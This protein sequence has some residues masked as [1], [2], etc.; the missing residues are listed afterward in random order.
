MKAFSPFIS[1]VFKSICWQ[2]CRV[3]G[4]KIKPVWTI[5]FIFWPLIF[6]WSTGQCF[7]KGYLTEMVRKKEEKGQKLVCEGFLVDVKS[8]WA[9]MR[10]YLVR[11]NMKTTRHAISFPGHYSFLS[12]TCWISTRKCCTLL[13]DALC[14]WATIYPQC[15]ISWLRMSGK[16]AKFVEWIRS[17]ACRRFNA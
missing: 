2:K 13:A 10:I 11:T 12:G 6:L 8:L 7:L 15:C 16:I 1:P 14:Y 9:Q 4:R 17:E 5:L 3:L